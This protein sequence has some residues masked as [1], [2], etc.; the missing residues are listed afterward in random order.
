M[1]K[2]RCGAA[3]RPRVGGVLH[4]TAFDAHAHLTR[5]NLG[6]RPFDNLH[7]GMSS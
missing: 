5:N 6:Y 3:W 2:L 1:Q 7:L 4:H